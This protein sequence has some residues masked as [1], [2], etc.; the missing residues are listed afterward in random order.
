MAHRIHVNVS[1]RS[2][3]LMSI[4]HDLRTGCGQALTWPE[5][6]EQWRQTGLRD[7]DLE[8]GLQELVSAGQ[9]RISGSE[10][11]RQVALTEDGAGESDRCYERVQRT[12]AG[13]AALTVLLQTSRR[14]RARR[15]GF[16]RRMQDAH[17]PV[18]QVVAH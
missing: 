16:G 15:P 2:L 4:F 17:Q 14:G 5:L 10:F 9:L 7:S 8:Q 3:A 13:I 18:A 12:H 1:V 6:A 11:E